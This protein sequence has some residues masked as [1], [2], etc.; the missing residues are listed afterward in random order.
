MSEQEN[1]PQEPR[2]EN[3][4]LKEAYEYAEHEE[5]P[6]PPPPGPGDGQPTEEPDAIYE[7]AEKDEWDTPDK[8]GGN[9]EDKV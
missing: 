1:V 8:P 5:A 9:R 2:V 4:E 3:P 6:Q 7:S